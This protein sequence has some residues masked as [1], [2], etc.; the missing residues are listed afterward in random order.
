MAA[1][2]HLRQYGP[3]AG[4]ALPALIRALEDLD[5]GVRMAAIRALDALGQEA[6]PAVPALGRAL[7]DPDLGV[8]MWAADA[9]G[10]LGACCPATHRGG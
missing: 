6:W 5:A 4:P 9:L 3:G 10:R 2:E 7:Q 8:R 1:G